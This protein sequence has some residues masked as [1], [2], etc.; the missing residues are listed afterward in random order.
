MCDG[1]I[2]VGDDDAA[3]VVA[4]AADVDAAVAGVC[5]VSGYGL[6]V[7]VGVADVIDDGDV[8]VAPGVPVAG[9]VGDVDDAGAYASDVVALYVYYV[10]DAVV[11]KYVCT[12]A[13]V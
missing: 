1:V 13:G 8:D 11:A 10:A 3:V 5:A 2:I 4:V 6:G 12:D 7:V 9:G